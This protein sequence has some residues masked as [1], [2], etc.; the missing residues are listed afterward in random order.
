MPNTDNIPFTPY[1]KDFYRNK[2]YLVWLETSIKKRYS[3]TT[4]ISSE[5]D[6]TGVFDVNKVALTRFSS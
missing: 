4:G 5:Q 2:Q 1:L 3:V 6:C